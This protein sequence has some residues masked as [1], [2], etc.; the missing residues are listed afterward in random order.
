MCIC[1]SRTGGDDDPKITEEPPR[2]MSQFRPNPISKH[3]EI[4][5]YDIAT[6]QRLAAESQISLSCSQPWPVSLWSANAAIFSTFL[7]V[8]LPTQQVCV[9][10]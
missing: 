4:A 2:L 9:H 6:K 7:S 5:S 1:R 3:G 8:L 10:I